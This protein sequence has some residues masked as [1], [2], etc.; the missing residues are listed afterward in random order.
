MSRKEDS[1]PM[2]PPVQSVQLAIVNGVIENLP[3]VLDAVKSI[4]LMY[5]QEHLVSNK[6]KMEIEKMNI[7]R[8]TFNVLVQSL[9]DLS[10]SK[11]ADA[12]TKVMYRDMIKV[13][14]TLFTEGMKKSAEFN[15]YL[16]DS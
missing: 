14:F 3:Q 10:K 13:L 4:Y 7:N 16:R 8:D 5:K 1:L 2:A 12:E 9:T 15:D 6:L 11:D